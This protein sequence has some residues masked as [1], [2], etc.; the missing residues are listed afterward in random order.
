MLGHRMIEPLDDETLLHQIAHGDQEALLQLYTAY[1]TRI[2]RYLWYQLDGNTPWV[3]EILQDT[4]YAV[5][6]SAGKFQ[7]DAHYVSAWIFKIAHHHVMNAQRTLSRRAEGHLS[8]IACD[9]DTGDFGWH[10]PSHEDAIVNR[11]LLVDALK[12]LS[13]KHLAVLSLFFFQGFS[14]NEIADILGIPVGTVKSRL[15]HARHMLHQ[16]LELARSGEV[17]KRYE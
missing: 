7:G 10:V 3:E 17:G 11:L 6:Q 1:H 8:D 15:N 16:H 5:W 2:W 12:L 9:E 13:K 4:F 14:L